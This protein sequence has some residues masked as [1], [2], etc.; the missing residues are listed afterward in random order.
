MNLPNIVPYPFIVLVYGRKWIFSNV[1]GTSV[2]MVTG[3]KLNGHIL[4][5][6]VDNKNHLAHLV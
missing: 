6:I 4:L 1:D 5:T 2:V 3:K